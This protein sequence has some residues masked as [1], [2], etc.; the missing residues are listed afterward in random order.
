MKTCTKCG[1]AKPYSEYHAHKKTKDGLKSSC[2]ACRNLE[3]SA[4]RRANHEKVTA[5]WK[6]WKENNLEL[7]K[8]RAR[9]WRLANLDKAKARSAAWYLANAE[10][11]K[12]RSSAWYLE[13]MERAKANAAAYLAKKPEVFKTASQNR[14]AR[15]V[16]AGGRLSKDLPS[17]LF[18]LQRGKCS[19]CGLPLG[20][21][22]HMDHIVPL[23][24][25]GSNTDDNIQL[26]RARCNL[27]KST[28]H[29]VDFMQERGYLL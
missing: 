25:G 15:K 22:Y 24:L 12:A 7:S 5:S 23:M 9:A 29:P 13:N 4:Y 14:R 19:C 27:Q 10:K 28:K 21:K 16:K 8:E 17:R 18:I 3:S 26:L 2:K 11:T 20:D 6:A 1:E